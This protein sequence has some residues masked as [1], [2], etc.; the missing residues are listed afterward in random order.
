MQHSHHATSVE[1]LS[2]MLQ[3]Y[4]DAA[5][6]LEKS[7]DRLLAEVSRLSAELEHK[8]RLLARK[9]RLEILGEM[10]AGV[11]HEIR[12]PLGGIL[13]YAGMLERDLAG[14]PENLRLIRQIISGVRS[15]DTIVGDLLSFTRGFEP[16]R[17]ACRVKE[18]AEQAL[19]QAVGE[20]A[21]TQIHVRREYAREAGFLQADPELLCRA[22][23]NLIVNAL[24]AMGPHG[25]LT[26]RTSFTEAADGRACVIEVLD[27]GAGIASD[28]LEN[29]FEPYVT[30]KPGGTGLGL[31]I[32]EK[33]ATSHG[34]EVSAANRETGG[35][36]F[37]ISLPLETAEKTS[38]ST[39][40]EAVRAR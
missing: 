20:L 40:R 23:L 30:N 8:N 34:G 14:S 25:E 28:M 16:S 39:S 7:H 33:I 12:N 35:A 31:A 4:S 5:G 11:A 38:A 19:R 6:R 2:G 21:R 29:L 15:L 3:I 9:R 36:A 10:S 13:L 18:I 1:D 22:L 32:V 37:R 27:T 26:M 24:E 17:R